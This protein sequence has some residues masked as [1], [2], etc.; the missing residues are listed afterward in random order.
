MLARFSE[1]ISGD[2]LMKWLFFKTPHEAL[3]TV[4]NLLLEERDTYRACFNKQSRVKYNRS[5]FYCKNYL[6]WTRNGIFS[7]HSQLDTSK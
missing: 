4:D 3:G 5:G 6:A 1:W 7:G 2:Y